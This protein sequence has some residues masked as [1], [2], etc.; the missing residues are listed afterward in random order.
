MDVFVFVC[1]ITCMHVFC[2]PVFY[3]YSFLIT[4][5][6]DDAQNPNFWSRVC[7]HNM[8]KLAKEA[9]TVRRVLESFFRYF[10]SNNS[11]SSQN[12]LALCVLMDM[13][14]LMEKA[15]NFCEKEKEV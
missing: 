5:N 13:Q 14:L 15:G 1:M 9:T 4:F 6:R 11:W 12:G 8:A 2:L 10:D 7:V 3:L